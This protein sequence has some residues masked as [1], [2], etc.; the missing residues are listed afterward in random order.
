MDAFETNLLIGAGAVVVLAVIVV[1]VLPRFGG[2]PA[3]DHSG[4]SPVDPGGGD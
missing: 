1:F 3:D 2:K 4:G